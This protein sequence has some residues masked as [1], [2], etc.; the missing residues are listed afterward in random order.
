MRFSGLQSG[1]ALQAFIVIS[2]LSGTWQRPEAFPEA[3]YEAFVFPDLFF[4]P[5]YFLAAVLLSLKHWLGTVVSFV[6]GGGVVYAMLYLFSLSGFSGLGN[7]AARS[8]PGLHDR[9]SVAGGA[10]L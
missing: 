9:I 1:G 3:A 5:L 10:L 6:A 7:F 4:I 8:V 2:M